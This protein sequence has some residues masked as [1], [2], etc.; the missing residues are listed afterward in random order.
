VSSYAAYP[1]FQSN[2]VPAYRVSFPPIYGYVRALVGNE[3]PS[4]T[5]VENV[6]SD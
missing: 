5:P 3:V 1:A 6:V 4:M 2:P